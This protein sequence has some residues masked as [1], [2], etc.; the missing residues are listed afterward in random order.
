MRRE[1]DS[2]TE[3]RPARAAALARPGLDGD[4]RR[5]IDAGDLHPVERA[6]GLSE[7][8]R[9]LP[10]L[11]TGLCVVTS[12]FEARRVGLLAQWVM[13][14]ASEQPLVAVALR[15][16]SRMAPLIRDS[17]S[18]AVCLIDRNATLLLRKFE[19]AENVRGD[20]FD[21]FDVMVLTT[22]SP[23]LRKA[24]AALDCHV[25]RHVDLEA[26][27]ELYVGQVVAA[28]V[29]GPLRAGAAAGGLEAADGISATGMDGAGKGVIH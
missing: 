4:R 15:T 8:E 23:I 6:P 11:P 5:G 7:I 24:V 29:F 26:D 2:R 9:A 13:R 12:A 20:Q 10:L 27:H 3:T 17:R 14:C 25:V 21:S 1:G 18:F 16:G 28:R 19:E 22:G